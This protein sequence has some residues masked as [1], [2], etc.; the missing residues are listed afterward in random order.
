MAGKARA[1]RGQSTLAGS[2]ATVWTVGYSGHTPD[3]FVALLRGARVA[4]VLDVRSVPL[5]RKPG[6]SKKALSQFLEG[7]GIAYVHLPQLGASR[8]LLARKKGGAP[9]SEI[10]RDYR[11]GLSKKGADIERAGALA[12]EK[13]SALMCLEKD[14]GD[15]HRG[16]LA[17]AMARRGFRVVHLG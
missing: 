14:A 6:F 15:C 17:Q 13:P 1:A 2:G 5:S 4:R 10:A 8:A 11:A 7:Q 9:F 3:S 12:R 16:I